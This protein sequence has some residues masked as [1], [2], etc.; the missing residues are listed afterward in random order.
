[1]DP[2]E[3]FLF[4]GVEIPLSLIT[5]LSV[6]GFGFCIIVALRYY[7]MTK[8][9]EYQRIQNTL[10]PPNYAYNPLN[11]AIVQSSFDSSPREGIARGSSY[12]NM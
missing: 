4:Y 1:M 9:N 11:P 3:E 2:D 10:T 5:M 7:Q 8:P 6:L 12:Q